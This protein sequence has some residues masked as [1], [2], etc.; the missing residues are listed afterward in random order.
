M[1]FSDEYTAFNITFNKDYSLLNIV[2]S[3]KNNVLYNNIILTAP[4]P[5][6]RMTN[7]SGSGLPFP[8][9]EI[10]FEKTPNIH[11]IDSSGVF[12]VSFK[13]PNSFYMPDGLNKIKPSIF[14]IFTSG[15]GGDNV[16]F[17]LQYELHDINALRTLVNRAS[18][19]NPEFYGAKDYI[20]PID[21]AEK[22]MYAYSRAKI[23][24]DIG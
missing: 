4:N 10:A 24:N 16:S 14:F 21:T 7:Y 9:Y 3:I 18:R 6:D 11:K 2:G 13:Y 8:N 23:E 22:V 17:R 20:L 1:I 12:N 5:I 19:K 15:S